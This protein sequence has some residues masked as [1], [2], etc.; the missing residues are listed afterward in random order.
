[1]GELLGGLVLLCKSRVCQAKAHES[2]SSHF[3]PVIVYCFGLC[4]DL[5]FP[6]TGAHLGVRFIVLHD[7][8]FRKFQTFVH[9]YDKRKQ[10]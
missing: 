4:P 2:K 8:R 6:V 3:A 5:P 7:G 9:S 10:D 1:M